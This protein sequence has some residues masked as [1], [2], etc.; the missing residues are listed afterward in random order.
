MC[1]TASVWGHFTAHLPPCLPPL[2]RWRGEF[3]SDCQCVCCLWQAAIYC[4]IVAG[5]RKGW[6]R[7]EVGDP[8]LLSLS[9]LSRFCLPPLCLPLLPHFPCATFLH[10]FPSSYFLSLLMPSLWLL[11]LPFYI[12]VYILPMPTFFAFA[13]FVGCCIPLVWEQERWR[14]GRVGLCWQQGTAP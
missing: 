7:M 2:L 5:R 11:S 6:E 1:A 4:P 9:S 13:L 14:T 3:P 10:A 12:S 8:I